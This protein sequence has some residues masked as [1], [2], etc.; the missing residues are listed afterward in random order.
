MLFSRSNLHNNPSFVPVSWAN[1]HQEFAYHEQSSFERGRWLEVR[2]FEVSQLELWLEFVGASNETIGLRSLVQSA[3]GFFGMRA[4]KE[5]HEFFDSLPL[6]W[7]LFM[8][9]IMLSFKSTQKR[10]KKAIGY[11]ALFPPRS[12]TA[13]LISSSN[14]LFSHYALSSPMLANSRLSGRGFCLTFLE[15]RLEEIFNVLD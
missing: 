2:F 13:C 10:W 4:I 3:L 12:K 8:K 9:A 1:T 7:N 11:P 15:Y 14:S 6:E 5:A